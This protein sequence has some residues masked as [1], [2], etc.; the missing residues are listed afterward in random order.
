MLN[1]VQSNDRSFT[2]QEVYQQAL[3]DFGIEDLLEKISNYSDADFE[4]AKMH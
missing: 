2:E 4:A 1:T 3:S